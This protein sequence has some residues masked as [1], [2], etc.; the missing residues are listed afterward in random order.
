M[1]CVLCFIYVKHSTN[2]Y[3]LYIFLQ[4]ACSFQLHLTSSRVRKFD[5]SK[6]LY[7]DRSWHRIVSLVTRQ[8]AGQSEVPF[9]TGARDFSVLQ[10]VQNAFLFLPSPLV[11]GYWGVPSLEGKWVG[12]EATTDLHLVLMLRMSKSVLLLP[13]C[14]FMACTGT[15]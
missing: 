11:N 12:L 14:A 4:C 13:L 2:L 1:S 7:C 3:I 15:T 10:N 6:F 9:L 8:C 5:V